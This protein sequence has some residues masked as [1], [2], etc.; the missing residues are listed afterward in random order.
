[1][2]QSPNFKSKAGPLVS[3]CRNGRIDV[4]MEG[5]QTR[6]NTLVNPGFS[7]S[8][9]LEKQIAVGCHNV[10]APAVDDLI[11]ST[12]NSHPCVGRYID[13][14]SPRAICMHAATDH[15]WTRIAS[16]TLEATSTAAEMRCCA[17]GC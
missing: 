12:T 6:S 4:S 1:M 9:A 14:A 5:T 8:S 15:I 11:P 13:R 10:H 16:A 2:I 3:S 17:P 7:Q